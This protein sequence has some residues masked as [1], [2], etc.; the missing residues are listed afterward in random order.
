MDEEYEKLVAEAAWI[1][2]LPEWIDYEHD[3]EVSTEALEKS[4]NE[5]PGP[6]TAENV[7]RLHEDRQRLKEEI[8]DKHTQAFAMKIIKQ[9]QAEGADPF[10]V[11]EKRVGRPLDEYREMYESRKRE[12]G[13]KKGPK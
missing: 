11:L 6:V 10:D 13:Q 2:N 8:E 3:L 7:A 4:W 1:G 5:E 12:K 9:A